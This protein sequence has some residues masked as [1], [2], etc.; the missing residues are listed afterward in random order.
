MTTHQDIVLD[1]LPLYFS[2]E[3]S[4]AS[5]ALVDA[6]FAAHPSFERSMRASQQARPDLPPQGAV[7]QGGAV[8]NRVRQLLRKRATMQGLAIAFTLMPF[9]FVF[10]HDQLRWMLLRDAPAS[11]MAFWVAAV[12]FWFAFGMVN[13]QLNQP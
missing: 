4:P 1:L 8:V 12:G 9:T 11:A 7:G 3:A 13:R 5:R 10:E 2:D 6:Y